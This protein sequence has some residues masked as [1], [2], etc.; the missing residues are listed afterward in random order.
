VPQV[1]TVLGM[2]AQFFLQESLQPGSVRPLGNRN[3]QG[4]PWGVYQCAGEERWCVITCR[5]DEDWSRL[6]KA[7]GD[8]AWAAE[9]AYDTVEGRLAAQDELDARIS[10]WTTSRPD[11][12]V[13]TTLQSHGVPAAMMAYASDQPDDP[14]LQFRGYLAE[15]EQPGVGPMILEGPA[16]AASDMDRPFIGPAPMLGEHTREIAAELLGLD[17]A[18]TEELIAN[19][20]LEVT[21]PYA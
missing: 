10:E 14:H 8:P 11:R 4:A 19:R 3:P 6:R 9:E 18:A 5:D 2:M 1:E 20:V 13:M 16:F 7:L 12:D 21:P 17:A 15:I